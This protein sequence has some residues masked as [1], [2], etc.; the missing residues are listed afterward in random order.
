MARD[1]CI[2]GEEEGVVRGVLGGPKEVRSA[3]GVV[4]EGNVRGDAEDGRGRVRAL[5]SPTYCV[6]FRLFCDGSHS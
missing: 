6:S 3:A 2:D 1:W 4:G 5:E